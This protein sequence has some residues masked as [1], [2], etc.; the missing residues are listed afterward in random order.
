MPLAFRSRT[1]GVVAFG[2]FNI[3]TDLLLLE[4]TL[5]WADDFTAAV[6]RL[7][8]KPGDEVAAIEL[9]GHRVLPDR[10]LGHVMG[11]IQGWD[12]SGFL[13]AV[14]DRFP[15]PQDPDAFH[16]RP[17]VDGNRP[18]VEGLL[19]DWAAPAALSLETDAAAAQVTL[20]GIGF[21]DGWFRDLVAYVWR[22][23][24][25]RWLDEQR[26]S[27]VEEM[28]RT[29]EASEHPLFRDQPWEMQRCSI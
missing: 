6:G 22:G 10:A 16:Q 15:F 8:A 23:G 1:H 21:D 4:R 24:Y 11:A 5:F 13:G 9:P 12:R 28:R 29:I 7:A 14:Y 3:D 27:Y 2:F 20:A 26:P 17:E 19:E 18:A 25:P